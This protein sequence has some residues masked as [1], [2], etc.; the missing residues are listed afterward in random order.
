MCSTGCSIEWTWRVV[1]S[2]T[3]HEDNGYHIQF[4]FSLL[5]FPNSSP[6]GGAAAWL[7]LKIIS[8][9]DV[10]HGVSILYSN[11]RWT[12]SSFLVFL[13]DISQGIPIWIRL[14]W[15]FTLW[16]IWHWN[17]MIMSQIHLEIIQMLTIIWKKFIS[18]LK[19]TEK[20]LQFLES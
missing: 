11:E 5:L 15:Y 4:K 7:P 6:S 18:N 10:I 9:R 8:R 12:S 16:S 20:F 13:W 1:L 2:L 19:Y 17:R 3:S 14:E